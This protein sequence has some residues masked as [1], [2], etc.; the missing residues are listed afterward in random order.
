MDGP[1]S[2]NQEIKEDVVPH[3]YLTHLA[4]LH[5]LL[6]WVSKQ[7]QGDLGQSWMESKS[8]I[9]CLYSVHST[10]DLL[11]ECHRKTCNPLSRL[12][13]MPRSEAANLVGAIKK[14]L[15]ANNQKPHERG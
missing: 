12:D 1:K 8:N 14:S 4:A 11:L 6:F 2:E 5:G 7:P 10:H 9:V 3:T 15:K 13:K